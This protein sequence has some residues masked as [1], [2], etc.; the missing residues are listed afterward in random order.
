MNIFFFLTVS[1]FS[2]N[3]Q[4]PASTYL[5]LSS[6][7]MC[8]LKWLYQFTFLLAF[9]LFYTLAD[10][11][12]GWTFIFAKLVGVQYPTGA[13]FCISLMTNEV[14]HIFIL[15]LTTLGQIIQIS[16]R[17]LIHA[18]KLPSK[19]L[20]QITSSLTRYRFEVSSTIGKIKNDVWYLFQ[21]LLVTSTFE[22]LKL[23]FYGSVQG[24]LCLL[25][26][27]YYRWIIGWYSRYLI[28]NLK[29]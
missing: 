1:G 9:P 4:D 28:S 29:S 20:Y 21:I 24:H 18:A 10:I 27:S 16:Y 3:C 14:E 26:L 17:S 23:F 8:F 11:K 19:M 2:K 15:S 7:N 22:C 25:V 12:H 13:L 5:C 6:K